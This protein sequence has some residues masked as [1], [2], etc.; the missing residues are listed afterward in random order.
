L[1]AVILLVLTMPANAQEITEFQLPAGVAPTSI[2]AASDGNLYF[3]GLTSNPITG[4]GGLGVMTPSGAFTVFSEGLQCFNEI[5]SPAQ[6]TAGPDGNLWFTGGSTNCATNPYA[7]IGR[8]IPTTGAVAEFSDGLDSG[9]FPIAPVGAHAIAAG[10]DGNVW[11]L[12]QG[13]VGDGAGAVV[14]AIGRITP[15]GVITT[16]SQG[17]PANTNL[18]S[19]PTAIAAGPDGNVWFIDDGAIAI[20][21]LNPAT[22]AITEFPLPAGSDPTGIA[23]GPD[24]NVWFTIGNAPGS[25][26]AID[27]ITPLGVITEFP[28]PLSTNPSGGLVTGPDRN[29][30]FTNSTPAASIGRFTPSTGAVS[31][32]SEGLIP[33]SLPAFGITV[34]PDGNLW[35]ADYWGAIGRVTLPPSP[36][37]LVAA[38]LPGSRSV[39]I[40]T[41]ATVF[42]SMINFGTSA[43]DNCQIS[44]MSSAPAGLTL[45][46]QTTNSANLPVGA[47]NTP[48]TIPGN[49]GL[50]SF[51]VSFQ[52]ATPFSAP[53]MP[54]DF[55]CAG[56][57]PATTIPGIDTIDLVMS[58]TPVP[59]IIAQAATATNDGIAHLANGSGAFAVATSNAGASAAITAATDY[60]GATLPLTAAICET[61]SDTGQCLEAPGSSVMVGDFAAGATPT[62]SIFLTATGSIPFNPGA[63]RVFVR[64]KDSEG[65][66]HGATSV[67]VETN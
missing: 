20:G 7:A 9:G 36:T 31:E 5:I 56:T 41:T 30:W 49:D 12:D 21:R 6:I 8:L 22:G 46:Y 55:D 25:A 17:L 14:P 29:L 1:A 34:G 53:G 10:P 66:E 26:P 32:Y 45:S 51:I 52:G 59:D 33:G 11:Y 2:A 16:F 58:S 50:Q 43:L 19:G 48:V 42:A 24:G 28:L 62:F 23:A 18:S 15:A 67:A 27:Q 3:T 61:N 35:F 64:F 47:P 40:G 39:E 65:N 38:V 4:T 60:N 57:S 13:A 37:S 63:S 54:L 44:L